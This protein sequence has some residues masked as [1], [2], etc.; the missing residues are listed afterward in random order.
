MP[1]GKF[2][3]KVCR[4]KSHGEGD[5]EEASKKKFNLN[6]GDDT[7]KNCELSGVM[8]S[9]TH[10]VEGREVSRRGRQETV[11]QYHV[12]ASEQRVWIVPQR[13]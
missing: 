10:L 2:V 12:C 7:Y 1:C 6:N 8:K 4:E 5:T 3:M 13:Q 9:G 11:H